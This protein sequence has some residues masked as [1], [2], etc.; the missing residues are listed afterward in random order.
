MP[1]LFSRYAWSRRIAVS[2]YRITKFM[3]GIV[4]VYNLNGSPFAESRIK[5]MASEIAHRV[6]A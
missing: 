6:A 3:C 1:M 2:V 5:K 4:G